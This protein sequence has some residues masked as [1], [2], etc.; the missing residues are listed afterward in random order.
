[1][2]ECDREALIMRRRWHAEG[3]VARCKTR[4]EDVRCGNVRWIG[5]GVRMGSGVGPLWR[6]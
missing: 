6:P 3:A 4:N 5:R 2:S 1:M